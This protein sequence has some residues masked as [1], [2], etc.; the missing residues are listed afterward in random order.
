MT[1]IASDDTAVERDLG[2]CPVMH[3]EVVRAAGGQYWA[4][5][6]S[7]ARRPRCSSTPTP[8]ATGSS[9]HEQVKDLYQN[10]DLFSSES[11][12]AWDPNP[13]YRFVPT[14]ID[15][16]EHIKYRQLL[17]PKF[18]PG[19]VNA[20]EPRAREIAAGCSPRWAG[21][22]SATSW[23]SSPSASR[24]RSF[25]DL[26]GLRP[27]TPISSC[28]GSRTSSCG[29]T[30]PRTGRPA[31]VAALE[32]IR[33]LLRR[34]GR[35]AARRTRRSS[36]DLRRH[37]LQS[38]VDGAPLDATPCCSTCAPCSCSPGSTRP[39][40]SSATSSSTSP[41]TPTTGSGSSTIPR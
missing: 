41:S 1:G 22:A 34:R 11:F 12:T 32:G 23:P 2:G 33:E 35:R 36:V 10:V 6:T 30:A 19:A 21:V 15:P 5:A 8:R 25:L 3:L 14:Q 18:S 31:M 28:R 20:A 29:S 17:N 16:P 13:P 7:S 37:L 4:K 40:A 38:T 27:R 26:I 24:P 39:A 9:P